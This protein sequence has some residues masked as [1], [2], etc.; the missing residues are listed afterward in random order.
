MNDEE[1]FVDKVK[2]FFVKEQKIFLIQ[3]GANDGIM[4]DPVYHLLK[5]DSRISAVLIEPQK[6]VFSSLQQN[7]FDIKDRIKFLNVAIAKENGKVKLFKN[8]DPLGSS[9]HSSLLLRQNE[10][11]ANFVDTEYEL[12]D[13]IS[14]FDL[15]ADISSSID[16]LVIDTEGYDIE[17]LKQFIEQ[18]VFPKIIFF[19][20]PYPSPGNDRLNIVETGNEVLEDVI[21]KLKKFDYD[22]EVLPGNVL[23]VKKDVFC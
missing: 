19:E 18:K 21:N 23:C 17:I 10:Y 22:I 12:V 2:S 4:A 14:V 9:G 11:A 1:L 3:I 13:A 7:Y 5:N 8:I 16:I 15:L 20:R 6:E